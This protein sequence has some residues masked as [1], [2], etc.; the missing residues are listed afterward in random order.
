MCIYK[1]AQTIACESAPLLDYHRTAINRFRDFDRIHTMCAR[2]CGR[3][4]VRE[5]ARACAS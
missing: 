2:V 3:A 4:S 1:T 5:R